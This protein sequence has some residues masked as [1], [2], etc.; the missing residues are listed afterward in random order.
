MTS[1]YLE[2][3]KHLAWFYFERSYM[4]PAKLQERG[5]HGSSVP[6]CN[7]KGTGFDSRCRGDIYPAPGC[8]LPGKPSLNGY[9]S[10]TGNLN[11]AEKGAG[12][13]T[14]L[15]RWPSIMGVATCPSATLTL[16]CHLGLGFRLVDY[17]CF[18]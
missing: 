15:C 5:G 18:T 14:S 16:A 1:Q 4:G 9:W 6:D 11:T 10:M 8:P 2:I 17:L 12:L 3:Y 7:A 13:P